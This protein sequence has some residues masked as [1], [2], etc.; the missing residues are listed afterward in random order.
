MLPDPSF[1]FLSK[2]HRAA[3]TLLEY[4]LM[5]QVGFCILSGEPGAGKTTILRAL[6]NRVDDNVTIG[7]ISNTHQSF[8]GL[9]DWI[10]SAFDLHKANLTQVEMHQL[11]VDFLIEE[12]A[13]NRRVLLIVDEA[14]NMD[15]DSLEELRMLSNVNTDKD[16]L[17]Q[18]VLAG[19]P[20]L[21][22]NLRKPELSQFAQRIAVD[23]HLHSLNLNETCGYIQHRLVVA[24]AERDVFTPEACERIH[25]YSGGSPRLINLLCETALVYGFADDREL[26]DADLVEEMVLERMEDSVV[27]LAN[28][29]GN[30]EASGH[31]TD[32]LVKDFPWIRPE[33]GTKGLK[34]E[35]K[36]KLAGAV[37]SKKTTTPE[38]ASLDESVPA[39][40]TEQMQPE[41]IQPEQVQEVELPI[42]NDLISQAEVLGSKVVSD[43]AVPK[44]GG[45]AHE[46]EK[47]E[48]DISLTAKKKT[49]PVASDSVANGS[50]KIKEAY[51]KEMFAKE[52]IN[53]AK[54]KKNKVLKYLV[55]IG[56]AVLGLVLAAL[57]FSGY[58]RDS[59]VFEEEN[60]QML[61]SDSNETR[62]SDRI[63]DN[64]DR[65]VNAIDV[66]E[67]D[68]D[69]ATKENE[70]KA[71]LEK[72]EQA[73]LEKKR[74]ENEALE[75][76]ELKQE[77]L[78]QE[79][80]A[81]DK[82]EKE[83]EKKIL[84]REKI[85]QEQVLQAKAEKG[86]L[87]KDQA[88]QIVKF[89]EQERREA[90]ARDAE[91]KR[92]IARQIKQREAK[93][94]AQEQARRRKLEVA[95]IEK[96]KSARWEAAYKI[97]Q[98]QEARRLEQEWLEEQRAQLRATEDS[99]EKKTQT[100]SDDGFVSKP[101]KKT[102]ANCD[103]PA[104]R[105]KSD[106]R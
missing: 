40:S 44:N 22:E 34:P 72:I 81:Q 90:R 96:E 15:P 106:C 91:A 48:E 20:Q 60:T 28:R 38:V 65:D 94:E 19:Q 17:L 57:F 7:L 82:A 80:L 39:V 55:Y 88:A 24:G 46:E 42:P 104:A 41:Q 73:R 69:I 70:K 89:R 66:V 63:K 61:E 51:E 58:T 93:L 103:G 4:G 16:Q 79:K 30:N 67:S 6:L 76:E 12:Y 54:P 11:F 62:L 13:N 52:Q 105:F 83:A 10:L 36:A 56:I 68:V 92:K 27:P 14:Q 99:A 59:G 85:E 74:L 26:I 33:G 87:E 95:R 2:K 64:L 45:V 97:K 25:C 102:F 98:E 47:L 37:Q 86:Q 71:E 32:Q 50:A 29:D 3:L 8:G 5:N 49:E 9:L 77:K 78:E 21:K 75:Q 1:L 101:E 18:V 23:Y 43:A 53:A 100:L 35:V 84:A 31:N